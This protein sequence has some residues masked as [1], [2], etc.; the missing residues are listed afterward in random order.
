LL[1][2]GRNVN[3]RIYSQKVSRHIVHVTDCPKFE[4]PDNPVYRQISGWDVDGRAKGLLVEGSP[5]IGKSTMVFKAVE[6]L[7]NKKPRNVYYANLK[8]KTKEVLTQSMWRQL[9]RNVE[10]G[11]VNFHLVGDIYTFTR[12]LE[13]M[14]EKGYVRPLCIIDDG[15][16]IIEDCAN[17]EK[18][19]LVESLSAL[20][21]NDLA[22]VIITFSDQLASLEFNYSKCALSLYSLGQ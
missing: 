1:K 16:R 11:A 15:H 20:K 19:A 7:T 5:G 9:S 3:F 13:Q 12:A 4:F 10:G 14:Q 6:L 8:D 21:I 18:K 22:D 17:G 2:A